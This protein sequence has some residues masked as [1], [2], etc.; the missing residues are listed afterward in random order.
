MGHGGEEGGESSERWLVSYSDF[1]TLLMVL[2]VV[3]YSMGKTDVEKYK[4]LAE[5]M[6]SAFSLGGPVQV[7]DSQINSSGGTNEDGTSKP[8]VIPGIPE[9]PPQSEEVAGQLTKMLQDQ[10]LGN[11]I[12]VQT[13]IEGVLISISQKLMFMPDSEG[14]VPAEMHPILDTIVDMAK[15]IENPIR[16]VGHTDDSQPSDPRYHTNWDLSLAR[17]E[18]V[19]TYLIDKGITPK[20]ITISGKAEY[21]PIFP[22]DTPEHRAMNGRVDIIIIYSVDKNVIGGNPVEVVP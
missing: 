16:L 13:N 12:S 17:A 14:H 3:L 7:I 10:N 20:R 2:F 19:A 9:G 1:I 22:N 4:R 18:A 5:S 11:E 21:D 8:I 6:R 15:S